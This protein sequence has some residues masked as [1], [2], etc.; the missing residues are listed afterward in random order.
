MASLAVR[1]AAVVVLQ[2]A[3][4]SDCWVEHAETS[5]LAAVRHVLYAVRQSVARRETSLGLE[6]ARTLVTKATRVIAVIC[7]LSF[8]LIGDEGVW[9]R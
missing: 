3:T 9:E 8:G 2:A 5:A 6:L 7:M 4:Q 1:Q